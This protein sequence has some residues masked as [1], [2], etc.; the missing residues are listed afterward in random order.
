MFDPHS[1]TYSYNNWLFEGFWWFIV[2]WHL[3]GYNFDDDDDNNLQMCNWSLK[4]AFDI[5]IIFVG[6]LTSLKI[7]SDWL[8]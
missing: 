7:M 4:R 5:R 1:Y 8:F 6:G 2:L 3:D